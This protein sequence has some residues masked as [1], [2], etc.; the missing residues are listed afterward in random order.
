M[1]ELVFFLSITLRQD[2]CSLRDITQMP[3]SS[4][5]YLIFALK[6]YKIPQD[7]FLGP[8]IATLGLS[9]FRRKLNV[10]QA[11]MSLS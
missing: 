10:T 9:E 7:S 4:P 1:H 11:L 8:N 2:L 3:E 6:D 5:K